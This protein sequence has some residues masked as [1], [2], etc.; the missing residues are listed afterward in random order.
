MSKCNLEVECNGSGKCCL[1]CSEICFC[2]NVCKI[3]DDRA[4]KFELV[5]IM[6]NCDWYEKCEE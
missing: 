5:M 6:E 2:N 4:T 1:E 3:L